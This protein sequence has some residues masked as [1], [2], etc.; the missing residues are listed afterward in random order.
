M[1]RLIKVP[2]SEGFSAE[3]RFHESTSCGE[4]EKM[5][6]V[7]KWLGIILVGFIALVIMVV[8]GVYIVS[9]RR[10]E[11]TYDVVAEEISLPTDAASLE[12][13][14]RLT[15]IRGCNDCHGAD[16][17]GKLFLDDP[18]LGTI[19]TANLTTGA[20]SATSQFTAQDWE[21]AIRHGV[22]P[23]GKGV[24]IMPSNE[25]AV[26][27]DEQLGQI[28]AYLQTVPPVDRVLP[29]SQLGLLGRALFLM[30]Q[31]P[32]LPAEV[33]DHTVDSP[34]AVQPAASA[35][36]GAYMSTTCIGCHKPNFAGGPLPGAA[37]DDPPAANL[38]P[39]GH[40]AD[41]TQEDF[42]FALRNGV[43]PEGK[44]LDP[45]QMPWTMTQHMT[46]VE[47]DALWLYLNS[48]APAVPAN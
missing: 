42:T 45:T 34:A 36:Y 21:R 17:G 31:L 16:F 39:A 33:I 23:D 37:P 26:L 2:T 41:W 25:F 20:G 10:V 43:T 35:E 9:E 1:C 22:G 28:V 5:K 13:G 29:E 7:V 11:K 32:L 40:L 3:Q 24:K 38:T 48:V 12:E 14:A 46:N 4:C 27:S 19:Y 8:A 30:G 18:L 6:T 15:I 47:I 44:A